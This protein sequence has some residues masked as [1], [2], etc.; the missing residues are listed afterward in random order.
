VSEIEQ[1]RVTVGAARTTDA[2]R[3]VADGSPRGR[4]TAPAVGP[5]HR[6]LAHAA[7]TAPRAQA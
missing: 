5:T 2:C 6:A 4:V 7:D 1:V 3:A